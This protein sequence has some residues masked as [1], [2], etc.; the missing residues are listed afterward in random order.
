MKKS[1]NKINGKNFIVKNRIIIG[2]GMIVAALVFGL[3]LLPKA[4]SSAETK[5][6]VYVATQDIPVGTT[7]EEDMYEIKKITDATMASK[8]Y[9]ST[10]EIKGF[11]TVAEIKKDDA[12]TKEA[13]GNKAPANAESNNKPSLD[14]VPEQKQLIGVEIP[15]LSAGVSFGLKPGDVIRFYATREITGTKLKESYTPYEL[16]FVEVFGVYDSS[17][18]ECEKSGGAPASLTLIVTQEQAKRIVEIISN[19]DTYFSLMSSGDAKKKETILKYQD[20]VLSS[21]PVIPAPEQE[22]TTIKTDEN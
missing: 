6:E 18:M 20:S 3:I 16:Q 2:A 13:F 7:L 9:Q 14:K 22:T 10:D 19:S 12:L 21:K 1:A 17:G 15:S 4:V 11:K 5:Y 8:C